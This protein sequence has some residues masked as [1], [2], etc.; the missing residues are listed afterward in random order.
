[1]I[2]CAPESCSSAPSWTGLSVAR[3]YVVAA[4]AS[5]WLRCR[6]SLSDPSLGR[7]MPAQ[8]SGAAQSLAEQSADFGR[9]EGGLDGTFRPPRCALP[10]SG[11]FG[12]QGCKK[13]RLDE[14][15][16]PITLPM[17]DGLGENAAGALN[18]LVPVPASGDGR[19]PC[20]R[21]LSIRTSLFSYSMVA[22]WSSPSWFA[23]CSFRVRGCGRWYSCMRLEGVE[24]RTSIYVRMLSSCVLVRVPLTDTLDTTARGL[25]E[26]LALHGLPL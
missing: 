24:S 23:R 8:G 6:P 14:C 20:A 22:V 7:N 9:L 19:R 25:R 26:R 3:L 2:T 21:G 16:F 1:M 17:T 12:G 4:A 13:E 18:A 10:C 5:E 15:L 11:S